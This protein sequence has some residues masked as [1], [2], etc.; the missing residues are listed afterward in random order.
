MQSLVTS[1][2][3]V[4]RQCWSLESQPCSDVRLVIIKMSSC[5]HEL[6]R[7]LSHRVAR[8]D[9]RRRRAHRTAEGAGGAARRRLPGTSST[10]REYALPAAGPCVRAHSVRRYRHPPAPRGGRFLRP[11]RREPQR[12]PQTS[13]RL[14]RTRTRLQRRSCRTV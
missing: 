7:L 1:Q 10:I 5:V 6:F 3:T 2:L 11:C 12:L 13:P 4:R 9:A 14:A 8:E